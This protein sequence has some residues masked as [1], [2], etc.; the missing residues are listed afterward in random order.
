[1]ADSEADAAKIPF[2][3]FSPWALCWCLFTSLRPH[4]STVTNPPTPDMKE[5]TLPLGH[6]P[7]SSC[8]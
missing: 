3:F 1:M 7:Y 2:F 5:D 8:D 4:Y 6:G